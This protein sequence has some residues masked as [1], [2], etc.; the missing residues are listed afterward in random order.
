M[1]LMLSMM[2]VCM[3]LLDCLVGMVRVL[4][5]KLLLFVVLKSRCVVFMCF[6]VGLVDVKGMGV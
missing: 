4:S 6:L 2:E 3:C 1:F 5:L